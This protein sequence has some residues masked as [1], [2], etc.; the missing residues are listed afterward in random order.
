MGVIKKAIL[1]SRLEGG[2]HIIYM[3][4]TTYPPFPRPPIQSEVQSSRG[5]CGLQMC[6]LLSLGEAGQDSG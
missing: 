2:E 4:L 1:E 3:K 5:P 6:D